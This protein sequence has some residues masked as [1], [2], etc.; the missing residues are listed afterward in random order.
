MKTHFTLILL[1][2]STQL[3]AQEKSNQLTATIIGSGSPKYN[4]ERSGPSV[5]ITYK[6][7]Q[8]LVDMGNG[9]QANLQK[10]NTKIKDIEGFLFT[11]H[12]LD[13]NEEF[14]PIF[15]QSLLS[16]NKTLIAGPKQ[17][18]SII[19]NILENYEED[20]TYRL[21]KSDRT[22]KE[23]ITN[24]TAKNLTGDTA[25]YIGDIKVTYTAVNHTIATLAYRFE[26]ADQSIVISGDLTYSKSLPILAKNADY[27]IMDSG[28][29]I[30][31][32]KQRNISKN[33]KSRKTTQKAHVNLNESALMAKEAHVKNL[34]LTHFNFTNVDEIATTAEIRKNY[35]G[36]ILYAKD[37]LVLAADTSPNTDNNTQLL[38]LKNA[39]NTAPNFTNMLIKM[40][41][42]Q[43]DKISKTEAKGKLKDNFQKRDKNK[44]G[45]ITK[46]EIIR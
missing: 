18:T 9:T 19:D 45:Y 29:A 4:T 8:I 13:H 37:L 30:E 5:L 32:G 38:T 34:V 10:N 27:L 46:D 22:L 6:N 20:I 40:D 44:D 17:T 39:Q 25:F 36:N 14:A 33:N 7:T 26:V 43:D 3:F 12:H 35:T 28:G 24:V 31:M 15:I 21:A 11:H 42:N 2:L 16:G 41:V 23:A 1:F